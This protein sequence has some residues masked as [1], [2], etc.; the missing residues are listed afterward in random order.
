[1]IDFAAFILTHGRP[2][3]VK[4]VKSLRDGGYTGLIYIVVDDLDK[5]K[6]Q[7][8][9][10]FGDQVVVFDKKAIAETFDQ[11]DNFDDMRAI[12]YARNAC[13]EIAKD[14]GVQYFIQLDDDYQSFD[15]RFSNSLDFLKPEKKIKSLDR[16][17]DLMVQ[18][19]KASGADSVAMAQNGDF[20]GG[21]KGSFAQLVT[22][23]RKAMNSFICCSEK[24]FKFIGRVNEDVNTYTHGQSKGLLFFTLNQVSL[25]QMTTQK[26]KGGM[27]D[28]YLDSGTYVK[29]FY[30]VMF[31]PSSVKI[32][33]MGAKNKRLHHSVNWNCTAPKILRESVKNG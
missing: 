24:P 20:I 33:L 3:N 32:K 1:M 11:A 14:L 12:I 31:Q 16:V 10:N 22:A 2:D 17:F 21:S 26:N 19:L 9:K 7:Y 29:S 18:F 6:D 8:I 4:T 30:S 23:K 5:T 28:L 13:F 25:Q 27:T 15:Y